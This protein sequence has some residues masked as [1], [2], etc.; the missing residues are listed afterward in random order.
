MADKV[1]RRIRKNRSSELRVLCGEY[2]SHPFI[3]IA[4]WW[5]KSNG[6]SRPRSRRQITFP[7]DKGI[8][9]Q[10]AFGILQAVNDVE[11]AKALEPFCPQPTPNQASRDPGAGPSST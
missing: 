2:N 11:A 6:D 1:I 8:A 7:P 4:E 10:V 9:R 5:Q 3:S